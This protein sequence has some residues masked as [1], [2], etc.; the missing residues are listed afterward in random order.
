M[1]F[2]ILVY[3]HTHTGTRART[4]V[5]ARTHTGARTHVYH[6]AGRV[7]NLVGRIWT[8]NGHNSNVCSKFDKFQHGKKCKRYFVSNRVEKA[9]FD[10]S[11]LFDIL[12]P[13]A[14]KRLTGAKNG[15]KTCGRGRGRV[16]R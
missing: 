1:F 14:L 2:K 3:G 5:H 6:R 10:D 9:E 4:H 7:I 15:L 8:Q 16:S 13:P 12:Y 11:G